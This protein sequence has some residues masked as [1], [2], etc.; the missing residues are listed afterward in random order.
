MDWGE[1]QILGGEDD[2]EHADVD[3]LNADVWGWAAAEAHVVV[4]GC[5]TVARVCVV[6][7]GS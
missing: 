5:D 2:E 7:S 6:V 3:G 1:R 4:N